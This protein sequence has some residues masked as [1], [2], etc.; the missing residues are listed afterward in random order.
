MRGLI[1]ALAIIG[2]VVIVAN[3][4]MNSSAF[5]QGAAGLAVTWN[6]GSQ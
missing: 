5:N 3:I 6:W 4:C 1:G 2:G